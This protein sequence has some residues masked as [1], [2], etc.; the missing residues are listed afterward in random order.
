MTY[1]ESVAYINSIPK[2]TKKTKLSNTIKLLSLLEIDRTMSNIIHVA[3]T[4]GKGSVC[5]FLSGIL[6]EEGYR[7]GLFTS[8]HLVDLEERIRINNIPVSRSDFSRACEQV[9]KQ[10]EQMQKEGYSHPAYFEFLF[11]MAMVLF[12]EANLDYIILETGIG[13]KLDATNI[14]PHPLLT[15]IT[16]VSYD[17]M[18]LLGDTLEQIALQKAGI[19]KP[20]V[21]VLYWGEKESVAKVIEEVAYKQSAMIVKLVE[22]D[23]KILKITNK[24]IDFCMNSGYYG[25]IRFTLPFPAAYQAVNGTLSLKAIELLGKVLKKGKPV[26]ADTIKRAFLQMTWPGRME[27]ILPGVFLDGAHNLAG[28]MALTEAM[29]KLPY[30][31]EKVLL[32]SVVKEKEAE[33]M[34]QQ[35]CRQL[36]FSA[37]ILT[38]VKG[39]R[40]TDMRYLK[41]IF[42]QYTK[43]SVFCIA[44]TKEALEKGIERKGEKGTLICTG[45]LYLVGQIQLV[46]RQKNGGNHD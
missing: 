17:H 25:N 19:I 10:S 35:L 9:K 37:V 21:P 2:F 43:A 38:E 42:L 12:Q 22:K 8:P 45:S 24:S 23:Y 14:F 28:I 39:N 30:Q 11:G 27:E 4:N 1:E 33:Q 46:V 32:F 5:V 31:K 15:V 18:E 34:I 29:E 36:D 41:E 7:T 26:S 6:K 20:N 40:K 44:D 16:P 13:G 3:G